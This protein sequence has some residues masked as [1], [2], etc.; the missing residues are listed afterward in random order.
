MDSPKIYSSIFWNIAYINVQ[1]FGGIYYYFVLM[2]SYTY[3]VYIY[4][5]KNTLKTVFLLQLQSKYF[6]F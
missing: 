1:T 6:L 5:I 3:H 4:L 2:V